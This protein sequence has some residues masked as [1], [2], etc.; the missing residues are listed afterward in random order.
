MCGIAGFYGSFEPS[1]LNNMNL[2]QAHRGPDDEGVWYDKTCNVGLAHR[3]LSV[4]DLSS[5]GHQPLFS[6]CKDVSIIYNGEIYN[7]KELYNELVMDGYHFI[8]SSDTEVILNLYLKYG[9][10]L[11]TKL[12]GIF[13]FAIWDSRNKQLFLARDKMGVKPV[14]YSKT[15]KGFIF[16]S[17]IKALLKESSVSRE[18]NPV[19]LAS[20]ISY[21][22]SPAPSTMLKSVQKLEP[23]F[24]MVI[25]EGKVKKKWRFYTPTFL[26]KIPDISVNNAKIA[27]RN[28]VKTSV[29]RQMV[30]DVPVGTF[31]SG[32]LD[33]SAITAFAKNMVGNEKLKCF[34]ISMDDK[35]AKGE[36]I[37]A[38][39]PYAK[40]V[41]KH[42]GVDLLT[43]HVGPEMA[44]ELATMIYHLDEP[45][46][47]P[48]SL[49]TLFIS[50]LAREHE[51][52]VLLS[53][54]GGDDI[55]SG[56]RR[57]RALM[58]EKYWS[59]FP[60]SIRKVMSATA[61]RLPSSPASFRRIAKAFRYADLDGDSRIA[62]YFNWLD[63]NTANNLLSTDLRAEL[64][65]INPLEQSLADVPDNIPD[66]NRMLYLEQKHY[67]A[68]HNLNYTDK[69]SM[70]AGIE[71]RV[72][73]LD[74]DLVELAAQLPIQYKQH[75]KEG[76]W[77]F[78]KAMEGILPDDVIYRPKTGF[79][80][81]MRSWIQGPLKTLVQDI[82]SE[83]SINKRKWFD[84]KAV[85]QLLNQDQSGK[86]DASYSIFQLLCIEL[87]ARIFLDEDI[88]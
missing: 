52:K 22:W 53:G 70:A 31:L 65:S 42:L 67:L 66:L 74:P 32:G 86:I 43:I 16:A 60:L 78:K 14:Y 15:S 6:K 58:M 17:E 23:G 88:I 35:T 27:V 2:A 44:D 49:N 12:N 1:L 63:P 75:G 73:L 77:I 40:R 4:R 13:A 68:D 85:T 24:A 5:A 64:P 45:Q 82:L 57:H 72:P 28:A 80:V 9:F 81:P 69:M 11:L 87:W 25:L 20:H 7:T 83:S 62:S 48:A 59:Y 29:E 33:S 3:R 30:A 18:I 19:A 71:V 46:A 37:A 26:Q 51:I 50:R 38:D 39:L 79:G 55:F 34:T 56:Y 41:A 84:A 61:K 10:E 47:D 21:L 54:A 76:K 36:G 8:G